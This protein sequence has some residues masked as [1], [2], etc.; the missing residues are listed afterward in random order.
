[1]G[2]AAVVSLPLVAAMAFGVLPWRRRPAL[3]L[4][5]A[6]LAGVAVAVAATQLH[7]V[8]LASVAKVIAAALAGTLAA[9]AFGHPLEVAAVATLIIAVDAYSVFAGPTRDIIAHHPNVLDAFSVLAPSAGG[10]SGALGVT[11][12]VFLALFAAATLRFELAR[13]P[14]LLLMG[15]SFGAT[16]AL[17]AWLDR[18]LPALPLLSAAF[19]AVNARELLRRRR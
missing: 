15:A 8:A 4:A 6:A 3:E 16:F 1:V 14:T 18:P 19:L 10:G 13:G 17:S 11:D 12:V 7:L 9:R 5:V 2:S